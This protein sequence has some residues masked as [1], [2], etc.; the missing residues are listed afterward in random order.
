MQYIPPRIFT[1]RRQHEYRAHAAD[2]DNFPLSGN[3]IVSNVPG[4][5][6]RR[7]TA[8]GEVCEALYSAGPLT[9]G[10]GLNLTFWSYAGQMNLG[11]ISCKKALPDL[12]R[13]V[14][15]VQAEFEALLAV[16]S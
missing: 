11:A 3:L 6:E 8:Q 10:T 7:V 16:D 1:R 12:R 4:P 14:D 2:R 5:R 9:E 15:D 13:L